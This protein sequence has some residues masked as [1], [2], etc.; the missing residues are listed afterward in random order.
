MVLY[1]LIL[2]YTID[3]LFS[4]NS[5]YYNEGKL[6]IDKKS[7]IENYVESKFKSD[8]ILLMCS[9]INLVT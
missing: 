9:I 7:I 3:M 5:A 2:C 4:V 1:Y 6:I 8:L